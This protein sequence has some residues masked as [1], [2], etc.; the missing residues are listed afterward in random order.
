M[1][2]RIKM[3]QKKI[4]QAGLQEFKKR[5]KKSFNKS[6]NGQ[7]TNSSI[8]SGFPNGFLRPGIDASPLSI[9]TQVERFGRLFC[10][11][12]YANL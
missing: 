10:A 12:F 9:S 11:H 7:V 3:L 4:E 8:F 5:K 6:E 1:Q 2:E